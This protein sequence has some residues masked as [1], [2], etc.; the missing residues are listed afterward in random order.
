MLFSCYVS[1]GFKF[2][3]SSL[4]NKMVA[5]LFGNSF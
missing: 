5:L 3:L 2:Q 1:V 4:V